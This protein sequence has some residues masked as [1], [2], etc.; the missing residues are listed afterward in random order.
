M[1]HSASTEVVGLRWFYFVLF[2]GSLLSEHQE[3]KVIR[4]FHGLRRWWY[5]P[6]IP[7]T[8]CLLSD[9]EW[10][11]ESQHSLPSLRHRLAA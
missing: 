4:V 11:H 2:R 3:A 1:Y 5:L 8:N 10:N 7:L 9:L 6:L